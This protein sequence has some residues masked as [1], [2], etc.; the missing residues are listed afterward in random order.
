VK[1]L[2]IGV[3]GC[4][5]IAL[6]VHLPALARLGSLARLVHV[7][8]VRGA[9]AAETAA[10][11]G[12][13]RW[14][15]DD[16]AL[17][18]DPQ[19]DAVIIATP[20]F[21]HAEQMIA[22]AEAGKH[23]LCEK[24]IAST[25]EEADRMIAAAAQSGVRFMVGHSRRFTGRYRAVRE[26][27]DSGAIGAPVLIREN[28]RRPR[29]Q[30]S[31]LNLPVDIWQPDPERARPWKDLASYSGGVTRGH[32]IHEVDLFRWFAGAEARSV[33]AEAKITVA[34]REVPDAITV[35]V[36]FVNDVLAA[37][38]L[39]SQAPTGYPYYHQLEIVGTDGILR[40]RDT[41]MITLTAFDGRGMHHPTA[42]ESLLH[43]DDAYVLEQRLFY[44]AV[45]GGGPL[46]LDPRDARAALEIALAA[47]RAAETGQ[48]VELPLTATAAGTRS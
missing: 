22:A 16:R 24:P 44:E 33:Q 21:L 37:C 35:H 13:V 18:D 23:V 2:G 48:R 36:E 40:A 10:R 43:I 47:A 3:I 25:L 9:V 29:A 5:S 7:C 4:G 20:E 19:V 45:L 32:A 30:Y 28:E 41:D 26:L 12:A 39:Y 34:G 42:Y 31:V 11:H 8:D 46:P 27:L 15:T 6:S 17:L 38:D 1:T 14:T